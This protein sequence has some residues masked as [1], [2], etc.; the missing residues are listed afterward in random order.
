MAFLT[1]FHDE[2]SGFLRHSLRMA[3]RVFR[4]ILKSRKSFFGI[5]GPP[6]IEGLTTDAKLSA[7]P[8]YIA[9]LLISLKPG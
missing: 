9:N 5:E 6:F 8:A 1:Q 4:T 2:L 7:Y 3:L